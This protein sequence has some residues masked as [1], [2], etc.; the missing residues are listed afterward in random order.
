MQEIANTQLT[1]M[2]GT[3]VNETGD[4]TDVGLPMYRDVPAALVEQSH[5]TYDP[6]SQTRRTIRTA[7]CVVPSWTDV[8]I[9]DTIMDQGQNPATYYMI[10]S[11]VRQP[12]LTGAPAKIILTLRARSGVSPATD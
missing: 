3:A 11:M 10:E 9:D 5:V 12:T 7:V 1:I 8:D 6:A 2:R 4:V